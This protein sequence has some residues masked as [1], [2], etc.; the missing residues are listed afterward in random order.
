MPLV[1]NF[2][3]LYLAAVGFVGG[4]FKCATG[5]EFSSSVVV[6]TDFLTGL[7]LVIF[8]GEEIFDAEPDVTNFLGMSGIGSGDNFM[9]NFTT[10]FPIGAVV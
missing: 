3:R 1:E 10:V 9:G 6:A 8:L 7:R 4:D 2:L 5:G